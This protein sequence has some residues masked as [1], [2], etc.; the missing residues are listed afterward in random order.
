MTSPTRKDA[1]S[2]EAEQPTLEIVPPSAV[3][4]PP[5]PEQLPLIRMLEIVRTRVESLHAGLRTVVEEPRGLKTSLPMQRRPASKRTQQIHTAATLARR[6]GMCPCCQAV[7]V[8]NE[9]DQLP[10]AE[11]NHFFA[12]DKNGVSAVWSVCASCSHRL[13]DTD[14]R[15]ASRR[16]FEAY[17]AA[18]RLLLANKQTTLTLEAKGSN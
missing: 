13:M 4:S 9:W 7:H 5:V 2:I 1:Q 16:R 3:S 17:Q 12:R 11:V 10:R 14:Y 18:V 6:N 15:A 8:V